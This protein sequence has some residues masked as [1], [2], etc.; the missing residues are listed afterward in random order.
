[1]NVQTVF[2]RYELKYIL[3]QNQYIKLCEVMKDYM[4]FDQYGRSKI[5]NIY[6]DTDDYRIIRKSI[7]KPQ[8][9]EKLRLR[10]YGVPNEHTPIYVELKKKYKG[11]VYKRRMLLQEKESQIGKEI[12]YF[13]SQYDGM[14]QA[15]YLSYDREAYYGKE[16]PEFRITCDF[17][18]KMRN[19]HISFGENPQDIAVLDHNLVLLEVKTIMGLPEWFLLFLGSEGIYKTSFSKYGKAYEQYI[20]PNMAQ[21]LWRVSK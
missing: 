20:M 16:D 4:E 1:M 12:E 19:H 11:V 18:I 10:C 9:K 8:Y 21:N 15:V 13:K 6:Y 7:E 2:K 14:K 17:H 3:T 5:S